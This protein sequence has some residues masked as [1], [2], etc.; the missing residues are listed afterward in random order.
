MSAFYVIVR[1]PLGV[2]KTTVA[3]ALAKAIGATY[4]SIDRIL[5]ERDLEEWAGGYIS[6][7]AL[8]RANVFA[9]DEARTILEVRRPVIVD[10]NFYWRSQIEDLE[11][12]LRYPH[13]IVKLEAPLE[14]CVERDAMREVS[15]G[16]EGA[17]MVYAKSLECGQGIPVPATGSVR[18][19]LRWIVEHVVRK[20]LPDGRFFSQ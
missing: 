10:G 16:R 5:E 9:A 3:R 15:L 7:E 12:R 20:T 13:A 8:R 4:I 11:S 2:G 17:E 19:T 6:E 1:G 18:E 14:V